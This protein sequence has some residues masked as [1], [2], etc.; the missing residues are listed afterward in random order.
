[1]S[2]PTTEQLRQEFC[3]HPF[4]QILREEMEEIV[5]ELKE[6]HFD[7]APGTPDM[8]QSF[9]EAKYMKEAW[10]TLRQKVESKI[11]D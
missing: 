9:I 8:Q 5:S 1:M 6:G 11:K 3:Q 10:D 7:C 4:W 2:L